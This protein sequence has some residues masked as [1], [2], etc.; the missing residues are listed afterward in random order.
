MYKNYFPAIPKGFLTES[1]SNPIYHVVS[2]RKI[3][4][5]KI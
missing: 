2:L 1:F 4:E 3:V 5:I